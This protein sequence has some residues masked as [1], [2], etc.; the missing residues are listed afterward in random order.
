M[1]SVGANAQ[2]RQGVSGNVL[3]SVVIPSRD[4]GPELFRA[5]ASV[6]AQTYPSIELI[7]VLD[8]ASPSKETFAKLHASVDQVIQTPVPVGGSGARNLGVE[9]A[10]GEWIALLDD[11]DE[12]ATNK[13]QRQVD[14]AAALSDH[15][16][17]V[18]STRVLVQQGNEQRIWPLKPAPTSDP[19]RISEYLFCVSSPTKRGEGFVQTSTLF[20]SRQLFLEVPFTNGLRIHQDWDWLLRASAQN[21]FYLDLIWEP[22]TVY[23]LNVKGTSVSQTK[24][25]RPSFAWATGN[26][27]ISRR[28]YSYFLATVVA[29]YVP[30]SSLPKVLAAYVTRS[31]MDLRSAVLFFLFFTFPEKQ[32]L[33]A[34]QWL[35]K[36]R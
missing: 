33:L 10:S 23:Y 13:L 28:A 5:I 21:G 18:I 22:L 17:P 14:A 29:R 32:R 12:W 26:P 25:W 35:R 36:K 24:D 11:D 9:A 31:R 15:L 30:F 2:G 27:L 7:V 6:H 1:T 4:A 20:A 8:N 3:V 19:M 34:A 16:F